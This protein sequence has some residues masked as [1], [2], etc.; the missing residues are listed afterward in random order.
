[1]LKRDRPLA[2]CFK[3]QKWAPSS[4]LPVPS[5]LIV[6]FKPALMYCIATALTQV[7]QPIKSQTGY[8]ITLGGVTLV[9]KS[10]L[11]SEIPLS[12]L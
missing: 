2:T 9:W 1:M 5:W 3:H 10:Q 6:N 7:P 12:T 4:R 11:Q 8:I